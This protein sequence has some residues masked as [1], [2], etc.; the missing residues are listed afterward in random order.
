MEREFVLYKKK[1]GL[2]KITVNRPEVINAITRQV[3][4]EL[5]DAFTQAEKDKEVKVIVVAGSGKHFGAGHDMGSNQSKIEEA[6]KP[7]DRSPLGCMRDM[8]NG[9]YSYPREHWRNIPKPTIAMVQGYCIMASWML[10]CACDLIIASED[11]KFQDK[12]VRS[13]GGAQLEYPA[14]YFELGARKAKEYLWTGEYIDAHEAL[15]LGIVNRVVP[16]ERLE[17]E[18]M[19]L[20]SKIARLDTWG[21]MASKIAIN[22]AE[23]IMGKSA[24]IRA[25]CNFWTM[26][27]MQRDPRV[28]AVQYSVD[29]VKNRDNEFKD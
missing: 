4:E 12:T 17:E 9:I 24:A 8:D 15:Q 27:R 10:A 11:A 2:A 13:W 1:G 28:W 3:Y 19:K 6:R 26:S 21:L 22:Q 18:T 29:W 23:D 20:A 14:M 5:N 16:N 7:R 25:S